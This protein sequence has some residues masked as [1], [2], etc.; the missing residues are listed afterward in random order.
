MPNATVLSLQDVTIRYGAFVAVD[1]LCLEVRRGEVFGLLG[2][3][4][5]GKSSTL[6]VVAGALAPAAG[7]VRVAGRLERDDPLAYRRHIGLVPQEL[8][9]FEELSAE[10]NLRF[11]GRLYGLGGRELRRRVADALAFVCLTEQARR[12]ARTYSGGMQRRLNLACALLHQ[13]ELL[14]LDEPTAG[15]DVPSHD[16][17]FA[18][19][20]ALRDQGRA[21][22]FTTH[23]LD[24]AE[25]LCDRVGIMDRGRLL[26][27]GTLA[28]LGADFAEEDEPRRPRV[29]VG[30]RR[31]EAEAKPPGL[32]RVFRALTRR[33]VGEA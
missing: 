12:P 30:G 1:A 5:S 15:L 7:A 11:F 3:N 8:A 20:R 32:E 21:L 24:E 17:I 2:P 16:A 22:V 25:Q 27:V 23:H 6:S 9:L 26:A 29:R 13:P 19:L 18:N 31:A 33:S 14:L 28:E 10:D 4:G